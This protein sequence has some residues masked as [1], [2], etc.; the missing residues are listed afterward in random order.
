MLNEII[1]EISTM[2]K[3][4]RNNVAK[5]I[6]RCYAVDLLWSCTWRKNWVSDVNFSCVL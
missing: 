5:L 3:V 4:I 2:I 1:E 6:M